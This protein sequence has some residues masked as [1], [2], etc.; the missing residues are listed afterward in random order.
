MEELYELRV[1]IEQGRYPEA[2]VLL[3]EMEEMSYSDK[4]NKIGSLLEILLLHLIK[5]R[6]EKRSTRS[7]EVSIQNALDSISDTNQRRKAGGH[8]LHTDELRD[9]IARH[10]QRALRR[11]SLEAFEGNYTVAEFAKLVDEDQIKSQALQLILE[12][13]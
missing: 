3:G 6:A 8:F 4:V 13:Q 5:Q 1:Y 10:Y 9:A 11:A 2:L 12:A 7:W